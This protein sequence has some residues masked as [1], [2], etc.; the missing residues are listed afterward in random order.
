[1]TGFSWRGDERIEIELASLEHVPD[2]VLQRH[3]DGVLH[4]V[5]AVNA[6]AQEV[7]SYGRFDLLHDGEG[8]VRL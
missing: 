3:L 8:H 2:G 4:S 6:L 7:R 1:M 5:G